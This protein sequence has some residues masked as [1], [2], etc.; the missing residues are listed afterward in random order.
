MLERRLQRKNTNGSASAKAGLGRLTKES[1]DED[2]FDIC[3]PSRRLVA[4]GAIAA[5]GRVR[6][7]A[8]ASG[9]NV[10]RRVENCSAGRGSGAGSM[11]SGGGLRRMMMEAKIQ[12]AVVY[13]LLLAASVL[14]TGWDYY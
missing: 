2:C 11:P 9:S 4:G 1:D 8:N 6:A 14:W 3:S 10:A 5:E 13:V 7:G 12:A